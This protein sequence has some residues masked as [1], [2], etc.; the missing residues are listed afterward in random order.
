MECL[1]L[2][3]LVFVF[4]HQ[5]KLGRLLHGV[6]TYVDMVLHAFVVKL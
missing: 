5:T 1:F 4:I 3:F 6:T 2:F